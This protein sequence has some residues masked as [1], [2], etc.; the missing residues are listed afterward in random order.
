VATEHNAPLTSGEIGILWNNYLIDTMSLWVEK[1]HAA[2]EQDREVRALI[3][4]TVAF[5]EKTI[6]TI[7]AMFQKEGLPVPVGFGEADVDFAAPPLYTGSFRLMYVKMKCAIRIMANGLALIGM[8][9]ADVRKFYQEVSVAMIDLDERATRLLLE[10]GLY[11]RP[12]CI[13]VDANQE[14]VH[15]RDFLATILGGDRSLAAL[16]IGILFSNLQNNI[17]GRA[18]LTG[19]AQTARSPEVRLYMKRGMDLA[20]KYI[21]VLGDILRQEDIPVPAPW[22]S[23][24]TGSTIAP[25]SDRLML[26]HV[27]LF[28]QIALSAA[29]TSIAAAMRKDIQAAYTLLAA[30]TGQYAADGAKLLIEKNWLAEPPKAVDHRE[31]RSLH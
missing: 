3:Q 2:H 21:E 9:R 13:A 16:E 27:A 10:K 26:S 12:P 30:Q 14:F 25:F 29:G 19:F 15:S 1:V 4:D 8:T 11:V 17:I 7:A 6:A 22:D 20:N 23:G 5:L 18:L 31:L 24:V 28:N